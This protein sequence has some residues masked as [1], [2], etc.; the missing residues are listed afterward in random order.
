MNSPDKYGT[1]LPEL[2]SLLEEARNGNNDYEMQFDIEY[3][4]NPDFLFAA[5][6]KLVEF[7]LADKSVIVE[8][9]RVVAHLVARGAEGLEAILKFD[10]WVTMTKVLTEASMQRIALLEEEQIS[11]VRFHVKKF[12]KRKSLVP[13]TEELEQEVKATYRSY[14]IEL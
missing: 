1:I 9:P 11:P 10:G 8:G 6:R 7:G 13:S 5:N 4:I 2:G 14:G 3:V 12:L